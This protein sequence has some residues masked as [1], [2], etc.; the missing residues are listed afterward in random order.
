MYKTMSQS[1]GMGIVGNNPGY[2]QSSLGNH[3]YAMDMDNNTCHGCTGSST[4]TTLTGSGKA[5]ENTGYLDSGVSSHTSY[6][7][8]QEVLK[9]L[10]NSYMPSLEQRVAFIPE[11]KDTETIRKARSTKNYL[12]NIS[13]DYLID[14]G[15]HEH[16][17]QKDNLKN[18]SGR[19]PASIFL[20]QHSTEARNINS[21][22]EIK[23]HV[24]TCFEETTGFPFPDDISIEIL[25][26]EEF[27]R[28]A[29]NL[30]NGFVKGTTGFSLNSNGHGMNKIYILNGP[31]DRVMLVIGHELGHVLTPTLKERHDEEAKAFAFEMAWAKAI[32]ENN[33]ANLAF[34]INPQLPARNGLHDVSHMFIVQ[35][36]RI[37]K[38]AMK[39]YNK[40]TNGLL[41]IKNFME[42]PDYFMQDYGLESIITD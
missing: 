40:M 42:N 30:G 12:E 36:S 26:S 13:A 35:M 1:Y 6:F 34:N 27:K 7:S 3:V 2:S 18:T 10:E 14:K 29:T 32:H 28:T 31:L 16:E 21:I 37:E 20:A 11:K 22:G 25:E 24:E 23:E 41:Q 39:I 9:D 17:K 19:N 33:I 8:N 38:N 4:D 5:Y 15:Y